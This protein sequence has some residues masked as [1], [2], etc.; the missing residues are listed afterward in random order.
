MTQSMTN[1]DNAGGAVPPI[2]LR[3]P[4]ESVLFGICCTF[5]MLVWGIIAILLLVVVAR[6]PMLLLGIVFYALLGWL[7]VTAIKAFLVTFVRGNGIMVGPDQ[8]PHVYE[9][10]QR[11][12]ATLGAPLPEIYVIQF[13]GMREAMTKT[14]V[15]RKLLILSAELVEDC[16]DG[17]E[18]HML[19]GREMA[20]F[21]FSHVP[22]R[23]WLTPSMALP[24]IYPA[25][26]RS[27]QYTADR[28]GML[29][30]GD[31]R[32]AYRTLLILAA[33]GKLG[34]RAEARPH[35][36]QVARSG[37]FWMTL[38][39]T[40]G[41]LPAIN[42]RAARLLAAAAGGRHAT[43]K[44]QR[45]I[46]ATIICALSPGGAGKAG[47]LGAIGGALVSTVFIVALVI[48]FVWGP[49]SRRRRS[50]EYEPTPRKWR[51]TI[52]PKPG[53]QNPRGRSLC[54]SLARR[55]CRS[56]TGVLYAGVRVLSDTT[57]RPRGF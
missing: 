10:V 11:A 52:P 34:R 30:C 18:L 15:G 55:D 46:F 42:W 13:G 20:H 7:T 38:S 43:V 50:F 19:M 3:D 24:L 21:R 47:S 44:P 29:V 48:F 14:F 40:I 32:A 16:D 23:F 12:A 27:A 25:W 17:L 28:C 45:S 22:W 39:H 2:P 56:S 41:F 35:S 53:D 6:V 31:T 9:A 5:S 4:R 1:P 26:R 57:E 37:G 36:R 54:E 8:L 51:A 49:G 33:G